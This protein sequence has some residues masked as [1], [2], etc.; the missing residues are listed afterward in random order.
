MKT[1]TI[2]L[3]ALVGVVLGCSGS[4]DKIDIGDRNVTEVGAKLTDYA[5][6]WDGYAEAYEFKSGSDRVRITLDGTGNGTVEFGD[7]PPLVMSNNPEIGFPPVD[8]DTELVSISGLQYGEGA[9]PLKEGFNYSVANS[10]LTE[11]RF[12]FGVAMGEIIAPWCALQTPYELSPADYRCAPVANPY[13]PDCTV[14]QDLQAGVSV[15]A[16]CDWVGRCM[17]QHCTCNS[18]GCAANPEL[19]TASFD[20]T[21]ENDGADL[22]GTLSFPTPIPGSQATTTKTRLTVRLTRTP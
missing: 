10:S 4:D 18:S 12:R 22:V 16:D 5:G 3:F 15:P 14:W 11:R 8:W 1:A 19:G 13:P 6:D 17:F 7:T 9:V 21:L 20:A 2:S